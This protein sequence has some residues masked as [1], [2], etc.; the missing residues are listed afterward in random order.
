MSAA[1]VALTLGPK[2][3][4]VRIEGTNSYHWVSH[5]KDAAVHQPDYY[6]AARVVDEM[7]NGRA[8]AVCISDRYSAQQS[9]G[10][11][12]QIC[13]AHLARD[14]AFAFEH[15]PRRLTARSAPA[16]RVSAA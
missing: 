9:Y 15:R 5:C 11:W 12:H 1:F 8:P 4:G 7:M 16:R 14:T 3:A 2:S 6:R 13:L 10:E